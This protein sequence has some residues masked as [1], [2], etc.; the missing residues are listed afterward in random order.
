MEK[1]QH[2]RMRVPMEVKGLIVINDPETWEPKKDA[3]LMQ[4]VA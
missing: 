3:M 4:I 1:F 2:S